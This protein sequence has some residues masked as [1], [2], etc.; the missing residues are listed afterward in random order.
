[1]QL[2]SCSHQTVGSVDPMTP[3]RRAPIVFAIF[4]VVRLALTTLARITWAIST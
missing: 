4:A 2:F 3:L 1:M